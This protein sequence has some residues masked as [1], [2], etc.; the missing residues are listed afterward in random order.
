MAE[1]G[2]VVETY[3]DHKVA[4]FKVYAGAVFTGAA[5]TAEDDFSEPSHLILSF[6]GLPD[7]EVSAW[8]AYGYEA[9]FDIEAVETTDPTV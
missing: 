8:G 9:G 1:H 4:P 5:L 3:E 7:I 2:E 6:D